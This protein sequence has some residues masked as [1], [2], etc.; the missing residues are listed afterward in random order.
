MRIGLQIEHFDPARGGSETY[1]Y[2]LARQLVAAGHE[3][4]VFT[5]HNE[6]VL[7]GVQV[8]VVRPFRPEQSRAALA[9]ADLDLVVGTRRGLGMHIFQPH[10]GTFLG[11]RRHSLAMIRNPW[12][13]QGWSICSRLL[14]KYRT[15]ARI[16]Q[17]QY[18][19]ASP[20][21]RFVAISRMVA[22]EIQQFYHVPQDRLHLVYHGVD[23][24]QFS[25]ERCAGLREAARLKWGLGP[26][27]V[28]FL[29]VAHNFR[30]KGV[31]ELIEAAGRLRR[32]RD[33]FA[34][35][36]VGRGRSSRYRRLVRRLKCVDNV[37]F[38]GPIRDIERAYAAADVCVHP[39]W[40]EPFGLAVL[41]A[42]A[43]GLPV[44]TSRFTGSGELMKEGK[45][46][47]LIDS[48]A[49]TDTLAK[50]ML[51]L[52]DAERRTSMGRAGR[53]LAERHTQEDNFR[54]LMA[55]FEQAADKHSASALP[56][57][58]IRRAA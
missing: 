34:V 54:A 15:A 53:A 1:V 36:V 51:E 9:E 13:R 8:H 50:R 32:I 5:S 24:N 28:C 40:Y 6:D 23:C 22:R 43:S 41:E 16:E 14:P 19:Q 26:A 18:A 17:R 30:L 4:H 39:A 27:T 3:V 42:W 38:T 37:H 29:L 45:E 52:F 2:Q 55:V 44:I 58:S 47:F 25:P 11:N 49:D 56:R 21:P 10:D 7:P 31:H 33:D 48:P 46:G 12:L 57:P 35:V 20:R